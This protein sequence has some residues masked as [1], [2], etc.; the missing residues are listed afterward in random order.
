MN[1]EI[2]RIEKGKKVRFYATINGK[3]INST[4][5]LRKWEAEKDGKNALKYLIEN[6]ATSI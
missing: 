6:G 3:R 2:N 4:L 1:L 5:F